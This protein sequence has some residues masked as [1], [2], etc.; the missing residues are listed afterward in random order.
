MALQL[1]LAAPK[2]LRGRPRGAATV[3]RCLPMRTTCSAAPDASRPGFAAPT[4][5]AWHGQSIRPCVNH[6]RSAQVLQEVQCRLRH[7]RPVAVLQ[8]HLITAPQAPRR[9]TP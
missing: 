3:N 5:S 1:L 6:Q 8:L 7:P 2:L 9:L 4:A